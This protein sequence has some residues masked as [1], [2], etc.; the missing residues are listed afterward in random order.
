MRS[1]DLDHR[2]I[3]QLGAFLVILAVKSVA[4][5]NWDWLCGFLVNL[6]DVAGVFAVGGGSAEEILLV[7][8]H[9]D[10]VLV[11]GALFGAAE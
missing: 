10:G 7:E 3:D 9:L 1:E 4:I 8:L 5:C 11:I 2:V 6:V